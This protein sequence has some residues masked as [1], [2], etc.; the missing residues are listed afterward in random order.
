MT[1]ISQNLSLIAVLTLNHLL[2]SLIP[3][4]LGTFT[5]AALARVLPGKS[6]GVA[7][8]LLSAVFAIPS[9]ALFVL[10]PAILGTP[11]LGPTNVIIA[12]TIYA[13][14]TVFFA[15]RATFN[16][17][18]TA[19]LRISQAQG[20][21]AWQQF[22]HVELPL[23][24]PGL[25]AAMRVVAA[26]T[27]SLASIGAVVGVKN[28]GYLFLDGF[29]RRIPEEIVTGIVITALLALM[30]DLAIALISRQISPWQRSA[31]NQMRPAHV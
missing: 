18:D 12:L 27:I 17:V 14:S 7:A 19:T 15:A 11:L 28:L 25:L 2:I 1:W 10:L 5:G 20:F 16:S 22:V 8:V 21:S 29:Q 24:T 13:V 31:R 4:V 3:I 26:S 6:A 30:F 23:A 9:L